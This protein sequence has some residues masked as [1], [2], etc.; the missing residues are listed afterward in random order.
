M[1]LLFLSNEFP[2]LC[3]PTKATFNYDLLTALA[4]EHEV[5]AIAPISWWDE[6]RTRCRHPFRPW[7]RR[8]QLDRLVVHHPRFYYTP[9]RLRHLYGTFLWWSLRATISRIRR[10]PRPDCVLSYWAH[11]DGEAAV[12]LAR[13]LGVP[14][15]VMVGGS[16]V[17]LLARDPRRQD[18]IRR[19]LKQADAVIAVSRDLADKVVALDVAPQRVHVLRRGVDGSVFSPGDRAAAR[20]ELGLPT[21]RR[22]L[23][24]VGRMVPVK[25]LD[26]LLAAC[27]RLRQRT[28]DFQ[29]CLV[30]DGP[31]RSTLAAE[32]Q[33]RGLSE[34]VT[35]VGSVD[36]AQLSTWFQAA[37]L[38][39]LPSRSE[40]IPNVLLE[41]LACGTPF[42]ASAV[43]GV[44]EI[45]GHAAARL[46]PPDCPDELATAL[47]A[48]L[49][50]RPTVDEADRPHT[51]QQ[52]A[53][54]VAAFARE[55]QHWAGRPAGRRQP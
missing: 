9:G 21:D 14:S 11:P 54:R 51:L 8:R 49:A 15:V 52:F 12:R 18:C 30:G 53:A 43:G 6:L 48:V 16:D 27:D 22:L 36:H 17:L 24:W 37:D 31:L 41:S 5:T 25:G 35:F 26:T 32:I 39:V 55:L 46:V 42:V 3:E 13:A 23:L 38:T 47:E 2:N 28:Q 34:H 7:P 19:V 45:A 50:Q 1:R 20:Q 29:L 4:G 33:Q 10:G 44:P 40:G